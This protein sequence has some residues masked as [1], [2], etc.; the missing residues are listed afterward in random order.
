MPADDIEAQ[1]T[2]AVR[3]IVERNLTNLKR[4]RNIAMYKLGLAAFLV[5][6]EFVLARLTHL[7]MHSCFPVPQSESR[8][9]VKTPAHE[10]LPCMALRQPQHV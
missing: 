6:V 10:P 1:A 2:P 4:C 9:G 5:V 8:R 7:D 3:L